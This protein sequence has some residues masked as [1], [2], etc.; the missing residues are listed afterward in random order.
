MSAA[1]GPADAGRRG[2]WIPWIFVAGF[3]VVTAVNATMI[4][5]AVDSFTGLDTERSYDRGLGYNRNL[6]AARRQ[7]ALGWQAALTARGIDRAAAEL[8]LEVQ[9]ASGRPLTDARVEG[10]LRRPSAAALDR[11]LVLRPDA[12]GRY[13][14]RIE[15]PEPGLWDAHLR[16]TRGG[17]RLVIDERLV[18]R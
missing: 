12:P 15:L 4:W 17:D 9:D 10:Q 1:L 8:V 7:Q 2:R 11:E 14:V 5:I 13:R 16:V 3:A 6:E 18:L